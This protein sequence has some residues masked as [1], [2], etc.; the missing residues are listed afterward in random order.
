ME[1][2]GD[3]NC[4]EYDPVNA[5]LDLFDETDEEAKPP[6]PPNA[7]VRGGSAV[8]SLGDTVLGRD[9]VEV[10]ESERC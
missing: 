7:I 2:R 10:V 6:R 4:D 8:K 5:G 9:A 3:E 1:G